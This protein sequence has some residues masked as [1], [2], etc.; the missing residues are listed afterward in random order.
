M[1]NLLCAWANR[2]LTPSFIAYT[3]FLDEIN[4]AFFNSGGRPAY[5]I[6]HGTFEAGVRSLDGRYLLWDEPRTIHAIVDSYDIVAADSRLMIL[7]ARPGP[8]FDRPRPLGTVRVAWNEWLPT[9]QSSGV[10]LASVIVDPSPLLP[11][12]RT[13]FREELLFLSVRFA[14][15][16]TETYRVVRDNMKGGLWLNPFAV[17]LDELRSLFR[18]GIGRQVVA[19]RFAGG[20]VLTSSS[21]INVSWLEMAPLPTGTGGPR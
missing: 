9:P 19:V 16:E 1:A 11:I 10:L 18:S 6:W 2:P 14:E 15:G 17:T 12:L 20:R 3:P 8:R 13:V 21:T 7:R 4:A 5:L